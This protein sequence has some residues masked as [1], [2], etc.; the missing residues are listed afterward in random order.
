MFK[1]PKSGIQPKR[2]LCIVGGMNAGGAETLKIGSSGSKM[3][4]N[5][6]SGF[7]YII[8]SMLLWFIAKIS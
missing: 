8:A 6:V 1:K 4:H 7:K 2:I 3:F 5:K